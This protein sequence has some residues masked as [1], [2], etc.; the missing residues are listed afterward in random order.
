MLFQAGLATPQADTSAPGP[1]SLPRATTVLHA[2]RSLRDQ[3]TGG[4]NVLQYDS[5][6]AA[7]VFAPCDEVHA[8][9]DA[10]DI[11]LDA[12]GMAASPA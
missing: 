1:L 7:F 9:S 6:L 11:R 10:V 3:L 8:H 4:S 12:L 5:P 2:K